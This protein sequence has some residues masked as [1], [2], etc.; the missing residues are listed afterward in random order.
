MEVL[1]PAAWRCCLVVVALAVLSLSAVCPQAKIALATPTT[2][3][4]VAWDWGQNSFGELGNGTCGGGSL[5]PVMPLVPTG[6][7][8]IAV[9]GG[10]Y[11]S[12]SVGSDGNAY[13][14][15]QNQFGA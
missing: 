13:A 14:W 9:A 1:R 12:L 4:G 7:S 3:G 5:I 11:F 6:V 15:G 8:T 10:T 2:L